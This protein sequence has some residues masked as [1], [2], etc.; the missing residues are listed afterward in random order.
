MAHLNPKEAEH[1]WKT[2]YNLFR[3]LIV[4]ARSEYFENR[5]SCQFSVLICCLDY[6]LFNV[7]TVKMH[8]T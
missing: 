3:L 8:S 7:Y 5:N 6:S 2:A 1:I 4:Q